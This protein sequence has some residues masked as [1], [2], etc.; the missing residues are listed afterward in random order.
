[1]EIRK[2][3]MKQGKLTIKHGEIKNLGMPGMTMVFRLRD[4]AMLT[5][6]KAGDAVRFIVVKEGGAMVITE[7]KKAP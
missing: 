7:I 2:V 3:D 6:L 4:P 5:D 1:G